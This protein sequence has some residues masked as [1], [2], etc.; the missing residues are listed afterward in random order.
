[1]FWVFENTSDNSNSLELNFL[2][3]QC[4]QIQ[5]RNEI[6]QPPQSL[7]LNIFEAL[8]Y[9]F[10]ILKTFILKLMFHYIIN[11]N[12]ENDKLHLKWFEVEKNCL[13]IFAN[14]IHHIPIALQFKWFSNLKFKIMTYEKFN[15]LF[16][17]LS[18]LWL[19]TYTSWGRRKLNKR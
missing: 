2:S 17:F 18:F 12:Y 9:C 15:S 19:K 4:L 1:M 5:F 8:F 14:I 16:V 10:F 3:V 6:K 11:V 7:H 13:A